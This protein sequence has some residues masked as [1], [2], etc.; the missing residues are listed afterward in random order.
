MLFRSKFSITKLYQ[1]IFRTFQWRLCVT[2]T[3]MLLRHLFYILW[4][5]HCHYHYDDTEMSNLVC[6]YI[7]ILFYWINAQKYMGH[8]KKDFVNIGCVS[9][10]FLRDHSLSLICIHTIWTPIWFMSRFW[11]FQQKNTKIN[12]NHCIGSK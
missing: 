4:S 3:Y 5:F 7:L 10:D 1:P 2:W 9:Y 6:F 12:F 11:I 8:I